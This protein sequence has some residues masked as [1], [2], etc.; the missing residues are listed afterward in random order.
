MATTGVRTGTNGVKPMGSNQWGQGC[1][2][3][4]NVKF[5][6]WAISLVLPFQRKT[7]ARRLSK[8]TALKNVFLSGRNPTTQL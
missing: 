2:H 1:Y 4:L 8:L 6:Y 5:L 3:F 7:L